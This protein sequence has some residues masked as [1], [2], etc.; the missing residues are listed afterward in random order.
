LDRDLLSSEPKSCHSPA[1]TRSEW[2]KLWR[3][4]LY[5]DEFPCSAIIRAPSSSATA[6][7][8][9]AHQRSSGVDGLHRLANFIVDPA[10]IGVRQWQWFTET[11][12]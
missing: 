4:R 2:V 5:R 6:H 1:P 3:R 12:D 8:G 9:L 10:S 11:I 7:P